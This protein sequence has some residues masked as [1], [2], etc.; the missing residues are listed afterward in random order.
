MEQLDIL[1]FGSMSSLGRKRISRDIAKHFSC[2]YARISYDSE[3]IGAVICAGHFRCNHYGIAVFLLYIRA[4]IHNNIRN[5]VYDR[6]KR[7][8]EETYSVIIIHGFPFV[9]NVV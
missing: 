3:V 4:V 6:R 1:F 9:Q 2:V 7:I 5:T 8:V